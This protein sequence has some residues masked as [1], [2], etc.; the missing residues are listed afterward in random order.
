MAN[1]ILASALL[2][3]GS[4]PAS[5]VTVASPLSGVWYNL[6]VA[7]GI[8]SADPASAQ[9]TT[10]SC[11]GATIDTTYGPAVRGH[12]VGYSGRRAVDMGWSPNGKQVYLTS[13][14]VALGLWRLQFPA[15][16]TYTVTLSGFGTISV[17][18]IGTAPVITSPT[19]AVLHP[20]PLNRQPSKLLKLTFTGTY[21]AGGLDLSPSQIGLGGVF[22]ADC[23]DDA[24]YRYTW[25]A[26]KLRA[27][28]SA[29]EAS[30][31]VT[32][33]TVGLFFGMV[34]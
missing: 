31:S 24:T 17:T 29:G 7:Y 32:L 33:S 28:T 3:G 10:L 26:S 4:D 21:P 13:L 34:G 2:D 15:A 5:A 12:G 19:V 23:N 30:G 25:S 9:S 14:D 18:A 16:A 6:D 22:F 27:W 1:S 8:G 20:S 11:P